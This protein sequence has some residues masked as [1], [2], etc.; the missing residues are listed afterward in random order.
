[1]KKSVLKSLSTLLVLCTVL[2]LLPGA[3]WA[4][5]SD[6][7]IEDGMLVKYVGPG[8]EVTIPDG[9]TEVVDYAF[10]ECD[11]LTSVT[12]PSS[13]ISIGQYVFPW[14]DSLTS[15]RVADGNSAYISIDGVLFSSD[16]TLLHTYPAGKSDKSYSIPD[17]VTTIESLAFSGCKN[18]ASVSIPG[19][20]TAIIDYAFFECSGLTN[21]SIPESVSSIGEAAFGSCTGL[22]SVTIGGNVT[23]AGSATA[24]GDAAFQ[25]CTSLTSVVI[26]K[27][28]ATIGDVAFEGCGSLISVAIR[29]GVTS[30]GEMAFSGT[31]LPNVNIPKTVTSIGEQSF[32][33]YYVISD[34]LQV[35]PISGFTICGYAGTAAEQYAKANGFKFIPDTGTAYPNTQTVELDGKKKTFQTYALKDDAGNPTNYIKIRD[36]ALA[37][38]DTMAPFSVDYDGV[39][40]LVTKKPYTSNGSENSTPFSGNRSYRLSSNPT[41]VN[42]IAND[43][44]SFILTDDNGG[45]YTYYQ[46]RDLG[47]KLGFNVG[48][49]LERGVFIE[50]DKPYSA[51]D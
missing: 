27:G 30:I 6:F 22:T 42:G 14:C 48:W 38:N 50:S 19:S 41:N 26:G 1:M 28:V 23:A 43:F 37:M 33:Y 16:K 11:N 17:S 5:N 45:D 3:A 49:T 46:L 8:G 10:S 2:A 29:D 51:L 21:V 13:V 20:V 18:L 12:I 7:V 9:V 36:L 31:N 35:K 44:Q 40:N 15:I 24:I 32:G 25:G 4:A 34:D 39:V 47:M